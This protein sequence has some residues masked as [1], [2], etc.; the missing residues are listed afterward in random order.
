MG[1]MPFPLRTPGVCL[2]LAL[3]L[4]L[5]P[6]SGAAQATGGFTT[7][8]AMATEAAVRVVTTR[9]YPAA[10]YAGR[11]EGGIPRYI[12]RGFTNDER[13]L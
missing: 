2:R 1:S 5:G 9:V 7:A 10:L 4:G 8:I 12:Q 11:D 3:L 6:A 13:R